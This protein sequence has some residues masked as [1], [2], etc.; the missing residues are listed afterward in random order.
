VRTERT[1]R[2]VCQCNASEVRELLMTSYPS[3]DSLAS[4]LE[5]SMTRD[6]YLPFPF[7]TND[8][9]RYKY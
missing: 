6:D 8:K 9:R 4:S 3:R 5:Q 7:L 1:G 2:L